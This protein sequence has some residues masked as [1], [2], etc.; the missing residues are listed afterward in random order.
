M[1]FALLA[2]LA[3][4]VLGAPID[5][6]AC[7]SDSDCKG[8]SKCYKP[9]TSLNGWCT[10]GLDPGNAK[11]APGPLEDRDPHPGDRSRSQFDHSSPDRAVALERH[12]DPALARL[13]DR[14]GVDAD[15]ADAAEIPVAETL[16]LVAD[17][18]L[19]Q[20]AALLEPEAAHG[21]VRVWQRRL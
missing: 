16:Q 6:M 11:P 7:Q 8:G 2:A 14:G 18:E 3:V 10:G 17:P 20:T 13:R 4:L 21:R 1:R 9:G 5:A 19:V 12:G 15:V